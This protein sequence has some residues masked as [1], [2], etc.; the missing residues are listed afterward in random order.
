MSI[1]LPI[2]IK[3]IYL[4][5]LLDD[6]E[7]E[8]VIVEEESESDFGIA[9]PKNKHLQTP[10]HEAKVNSDSSATIDNFLTSIRR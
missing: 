3:G 6:G 4:L 2:K 10:E 1:Y 5:V 9:N 8:L 7:G